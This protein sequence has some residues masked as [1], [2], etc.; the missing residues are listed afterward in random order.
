MALSPPMHIGSKGVWT[1]E[2]QQDW[3]NFQVKQQLDGVDR[4]LFLLQSRVF[5]ATTRVFLTTIRVV[6]LQLTYRPPK[7]VYRE[8]IYR[9]F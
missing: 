8:F 7:A 9:E 6:L 5:L 2:M 3:N 4:V 1:L